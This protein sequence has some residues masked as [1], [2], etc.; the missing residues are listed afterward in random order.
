MNVDSKPPGGILSEPL[1]PEHNLSAFTCGNPKL[2]AWLRSYAL[3]AEARRT[4][5]TY[6]WRRRQGLIIAYY[7]LA[8]DVIVRVG[9]PPSFSHGE[10]ERIPSVLLARLAVSRSE[11]GSGLGGAVLGEAFD[12]VSAL[13]VGARYLVV[14]AIDENA[15]AFYDHY[16]F[17]RVPGSMRLVHKTAGPL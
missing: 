8:A 12:R 3:Q 16:G 17:R 15:V 2:D 1:A 10:P 14:D 6:V 9:L 4:A 11:Q 5:R 7:S 13:G